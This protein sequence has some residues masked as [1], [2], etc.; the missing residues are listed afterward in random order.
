VLALTKDADSVELKL[1]VPE[2]ERPGRQCLGIDALD[3]QIPQ[4]FLSD[5][6]RSGGSTSSA[7]MKGTLGTT[8]VKKVAPSSR[9]I[10]SCTPRSIHKLY[11]KEQRGVVETYAPLESALTTWRSSTRSPCKVKFGSPP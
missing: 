7:S 10:P 11:S 8:D 5:T 4:S 9:S 1:T 2:A 3:A 6:R